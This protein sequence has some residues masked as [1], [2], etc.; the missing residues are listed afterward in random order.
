MLKNG[1]CI[2]LCAVTEKVHHIISLCTGVRAF[3]KNFLTLER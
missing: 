3:G 2:I 1:K